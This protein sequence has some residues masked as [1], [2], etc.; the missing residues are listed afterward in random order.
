MTSLDSEQLEKLVNY[1][2]DHI[3]SL[4][5]DNRKLRE[6]IQDLK[7]PGRYVN[8][9]SGRMDTKCMA[10]GILKKPYGKSRKKK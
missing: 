2:Q 5:H 1:M 10:S 4:K 6:E 7:E 9:I 8:T 3:D